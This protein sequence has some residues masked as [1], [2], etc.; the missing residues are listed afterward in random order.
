MYVHAQHFNCLFQFAQKLESII[1]TIQECWDADTEARLNA[2]TVQERFSRVFGALFTAYS[3]ADTWE[4][5]KEYCTMLLEQDDSTK[6]VR[7]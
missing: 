7:W 5:N 3:G 4:G 2:K 6:K 1:E